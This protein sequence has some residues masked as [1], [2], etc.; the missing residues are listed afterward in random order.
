[1]FSR[2]MEAVL[3]RIIGL[4]VHRREKLTVKERAAQQA[5]LQKLVIRKSKTSKPVVIAMIGLIGSGKSSVAQYLAELIGATVIAGDDLRI[6]LRKQDE[7]YEKMRAIAED[8]VLQIVRDGGNVILDS[9]FIDAKKRASLR[10]K[11][12]KLKV[13]VEF[14]C[15]YTEDIDTSIGRAITATYSDHPE[16]FFGGAKSVWQGKNK[17]GVVKIREMMRRIPLHYKWSS[18]GGGTWKIKNPPC[19]SI[20]DIDTTD[21][22]AWKRD[23]EI[24]AKKLL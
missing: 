24:V 12:R 8:V 18:E 11:A 20:A 17:G 3:P 9:D 22:K 1:M 14:L 2:L 21:P 4:M 15:V 7:Q 19:K 10:E 5:F 6:E 13:R 23:V 16:D